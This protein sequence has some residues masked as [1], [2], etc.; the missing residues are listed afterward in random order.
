MPS[1]KRIARFAPLIGVFIGLFQAS[2]LILLSNLNWPDESL[3]FIC[4]AIGIGLTGGLH[5]D[6]LVDTADGISAGSKR[7]FEAMK[8]SRVGAIGLLVL[9]FIISLQ[10]ASLFKLKL[11]YL[12]ALP[13]ASFWGR[14]SQVWAIGN[15]P[16][17]E[18]GGSSMFH[19][20][21][22]SGNYRESIPSII[23]LMLITILLIKLKI[24]Y[25]IKICFIIS[26][27]SGIIP[28]IFI[29]NLLAH[30]LKY[31]SGDSYGASVVLV[32]TFMLFTFAIIMPGSL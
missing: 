12:F 3:P 25:S 31:L 2:T 32:E 13:L 26:T 22:W 15:H 23:F 14:Y 28:A 16:Y 5:F 29:P 24:V 11:F 19:K 9:V 6:G 17:L 20:H 27:L 21:N 18:E 1:F 10:I 30:R 8:D 4:I 7:T